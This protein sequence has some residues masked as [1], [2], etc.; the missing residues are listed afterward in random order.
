MYPQQQINLNSIMGMMAV[1][2]MMVMMFKA[3]SNGEP[4][5]HHSLEFID[6]RGL[7]RALSWSDFVSRAEEGI[8]EI[9]SLVDKGNR[10]MAHEEVMHTIRKVDEISRRSDPEIMERYLPE[11]TEW[12]HI[13]KQQI[14]TK[15]DD[16]LVSNLFYMQDTFSRLYGRCLI[17]AYRKATSLT[18]AS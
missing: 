4:S 12:L 6:E 8:V 2:V 16:V 9:T 14:E 10:D 13:A 5:H 17:Q 15:P 11:V 1:V 3:L 7:T 18:P